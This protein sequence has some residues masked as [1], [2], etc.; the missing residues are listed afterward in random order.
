MG[1]G[2]LTAG[3]LHLLFNRIFDNSKLIVNRPAILF[4]HDLLIIIK[5]FAVIPLGCNLVKFV[6]E[7]IQLVIRE[8]RVSF[9]SLSVFGR[10]PK[11]YLTLNRNFTVNLP[12]VVLVDKLIEKIGRR[13]QNEYQKED[14]NQVHFVC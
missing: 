10:L 2:D 4:Q 6:E 1:W 9:C 8:I 7:V 13:R 11:H 3:F 5:G 12:D 14:F